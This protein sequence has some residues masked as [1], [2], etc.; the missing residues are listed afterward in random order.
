MFTGDSSGDWLFRALHETGFASQPNSTGK[1]DGLQVKN[2]FISAVCR[3]APPDNKPLPSEIENCSSFL[4]K[5]IKLLRNVK[6]VLC[7]GQLAFNRYCR[8]HS[9]KG[10]EFS[11]GKKCKLDNGT[12]LVSSYHPSRQNTNTGRLKWNDW[13]KVF[14]D[15]CSII[16]V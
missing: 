7:L 13:L 6:V 8:L 5:E 15:I 11:H 10:L 12:V 16:G 4:E 2:I 3:C 1:D 9:L 14:Q